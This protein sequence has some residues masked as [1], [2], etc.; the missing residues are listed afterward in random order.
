MRSRRTREW[1]KGLIIAAGAAALV[2]AMP[3][4]GSASSDAVT[5]G[6]VQKEVKE[7][8]DAIKNYTYEKREDALQ[9]AKKALGELDAELARREEKLSQ[10]WSEMSELARERA[11]ETSAE[12]RQRRQELAEWYG[13][14]KHGSQRAWD[15]IK[16]GFTDAYAELK[17]AWEQSGTD[18]KK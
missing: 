10:D 2:A 16:S 12:L 18:E 1:T 7:A 15:E 11:R 8:M 5:R 4:A 17:K 14:M 3:L 6:E 13:G 9:R